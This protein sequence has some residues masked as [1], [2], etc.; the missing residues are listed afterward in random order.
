M[1]FRFGCRRLWE[2]LIEIGGDGPVGRTEIRAPVR[3]ALSL[4]LEIEGGF[5]I[6]KGDFLLYK[7]RDGRQRFERED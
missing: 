4:G 5:V 6:E 2:R 3:G 1:I 7:V